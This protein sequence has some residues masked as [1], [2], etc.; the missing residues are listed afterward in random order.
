MLKGII[1]FLD[2]LEEYV[3]V[4]LF[5]LTLIL[6]GTVVVTRYFFAYTPSWAEQ[7]ARIF[8]VWI[9]FAGI[10]MAA[11]KGMHLKVTAIT[12]VL[13]KRVSPFVMLFGDVVTAVAA[14]VIFLKLFNM[15]LVVY[16][17]GQTFAAMP[18]VPVWIMY[19]GGV[20]GMLGMT[21]RVVQAGI[22]PGLREIMGQNKTMPKNANEKA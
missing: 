5:T 21:I 13:P 19:M 10:S 17:R 15:T 22:I 14:G 7:T 16:E 4:I 20:L 18:S 2:K 8:F 11:R 3:I 6:L 1:R 12:M 9:S